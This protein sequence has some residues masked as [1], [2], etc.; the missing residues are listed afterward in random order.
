MSST[1]TH[2]E[3]KLYKNTKL[4]TVSLAVKLNCYSKTHFKTK[5]KMN[6]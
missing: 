2:N 5:N 6:I 4:N 1:I 3:Y